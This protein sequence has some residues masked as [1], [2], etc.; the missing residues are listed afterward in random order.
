[1]RDRLPHDIGEPG[2]ADRIPHQPE[3]AVGSAALVSAGVDDEPQGEMGEDLLDLPRAAGA[4][5]PRPARRPRKPRRALRP[6][7]ACRGVR[8]SRRAGPSA[9][10]GGRGRRRPRDARRTPRRLAR[11]FGFASALRGKVVGR[12]G[13]ERARS[14][15]RAGRPA[16]SG[17]R[18]RQIV[19]PMSISAWAKSP[20]RRGG[21]SARAAAAIALRCS[22]IGASSAVRRAR[23]R[24]MLPSTGA[25]W[26]SKAIAA[27]AAAV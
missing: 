27:I 24:A 4:S 9:A 19:A 17:F 23:M 10:A 15:L 5:A 3:M 11:G 21:A 8:R 16:Q 20:A 13:A 7:R 1:M 18:G 12:A 2:L 25:A 6:S 22:A 26:R 14:R